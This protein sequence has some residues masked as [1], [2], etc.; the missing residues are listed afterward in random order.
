MKNTSGLELR[1]FVA[2]EILFGVGARHLVGQY[3][4][5]FNARNVMSFWP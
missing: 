2:P 4:R 5:N 3:A 1:K